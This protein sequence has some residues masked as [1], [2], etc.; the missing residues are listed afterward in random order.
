M[1]SLLQ[2][3]QLFHIS[4]KKKK[5]WRTEE[6]NLWPLAGHGVIGVQ[7]WAREG[8]PVIGVHGQWHGF[9]PSLALQDLSSQA[10]VF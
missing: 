7:L 8:V 10:E 1:K 2:F 3:W 4:F 9:F 6:K 5:S